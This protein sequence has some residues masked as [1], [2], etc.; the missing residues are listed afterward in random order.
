MTPQKM[1]MAKALVA[2]PNRTIAEICEVLK[3]LLATYYR[4]IS[5]S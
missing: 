2:D 3:I 1:V 4:H 5:Q